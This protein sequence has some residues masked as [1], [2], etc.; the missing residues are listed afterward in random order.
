[1]ADNQPQRE[2]SDSA[3]ETLARTFQEMKFRKKLLGGVDEADVW[4]KLEK[5]QQEYETL[6]NRQAAHY[7]ALLEEREK[8]LARL[9]QDRGGVARG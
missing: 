8:A 6:Y 5:L 1:M 3:M 2:S 9:T 4:R 7:Q